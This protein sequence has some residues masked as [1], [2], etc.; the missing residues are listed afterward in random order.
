[1]VIVLWAVNFWIYCAG[2]SKQ[3][4]YSLWLLICLSEH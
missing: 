2:L 3:A 4:E 1:M